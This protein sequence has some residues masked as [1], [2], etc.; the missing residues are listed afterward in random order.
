MEFWYEGRTEGGARLQ[1]QKAREN[2][3]S[4]RTRAPSTETILVGEL[5]RTNRRDGP[6]MGTVRVLRE[7]FRES[8]SSGLTACCCLRRRVI[9]PQDLWHDSHSSDHVPN[10]DPRPI[11][12]VG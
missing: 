3:V 1:A 7:A 4:R 5:R 2:P 12:A 10:G 8:R 6:I 11:L 9:R